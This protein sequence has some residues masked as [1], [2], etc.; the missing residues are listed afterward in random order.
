MKRFTGLGAAGVLLILAAACAA[1]KTGPVAPELFAVLPSKEGKV[2]SIVVNSAGS[3]RV[4]DTAYGAQL[5]Q[6]SGEMVGGKLTEADVRASFGSTLQALPGR[7]ASFIL[8]FLEG[9]DELTVESKKE[10]ERVFIELA[11]RPLPDIVVI[12]HT[13]T[14]GSGPFN[15]KLSLQRAERLREMMVFMGLA[16]ERV[17]AAGRG[18]RELLVPTEDNVSEPRNR[19]VEINVR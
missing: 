3:S 4:I 2:G 17:Q 18:E 14:V 8:Y 5:I 7:P 11:R 9:K 13:D 1:P 10:L 15:D 19:R 16:A 6:P 12:G